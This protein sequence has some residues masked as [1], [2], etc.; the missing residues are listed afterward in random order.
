MDP[1]ETLVTKLNELLDA[2]QK[3]E[4][5]DVKTIVDWFEQ[6]VD[7]NRTLLPAVYAG[8][9]PCPTQDDLVIA[10][11][12]HNQKCVL[13]YLLIETDI[14]EYL[15]DSTQHITQVTE[16]RTEAVRHALR[17]EDFEM[18]EKLY[19]YWSGDLYWNGYEKNKFEDLGKILKDAES[20]KNFFSWVCNIF[21]KILI[22][23]RFKDI[24][25]QLLI[26]F[27]CLVTL[28]DFQQELYS[29]LPEPLSHD[30]PAE[31]TARVLL[32]VLS[33]YD[34]YSN[35]EKVR[36]PNVDH[37][38]EFQLKSYFEDNNSTYFK[39]LAYIK[40]EVYFRKLDFN[41]ALLLLEKLHIIRNHLEARFNKSNAFLNDNTILQKDY[42]TKSSSYNDIE[43]AIYHLIYRTSED[44][45][46]YLPADRQLTVETHHLGIHN[47]IIGKL[48]T[49]YDL[50]KLYNGPV[51]YFEREH[52]KTC[53]GNLREILNDYFIQPDPYHG[54]GKP[55]NKDEKILDKNYLKPM[56]YVSDHYSLNKIVTYIEALEQTAKA[57]VIMIE[58]VL[59]VTGEMV[60]A[61]EKTSHLSEMTKTF[62]PI[63]V[64]KDTIKH[65][66]GIRTFLSHTDKE[67]LS[68]RIDIENKQADMLLNVKDEL[69]KIKERIVLI[70]DLCKSILDKSLLQKGLKLLEKRIEKLPGGARQRR[71]EICRLYKERGNDLVSEDGEYYRN[72]WEPA[73]LSYQL[74]KE[75]THLLQNLDEISSKKKRI[76]NEINK[77]FTKMLSTY[78]Q[79]AK[80]T[81]ELMRRNNRCVESVNKTLNIHNIPNLKYSPTSQDINEARDKLKRKINDIDSIEFPTDFSRHWKS[82][83]RMVNL[84]LNGDIPGDISFDMFASIGKFGTNNTPDPSNID[85]LY[86]ILEKMELVYLMSNQSTNNTNACQK[87]NVLFTEI[88]NLYENTV[89]KTEKLKKFTK[90]HPTNGQEELIMCFVNRIYLLRNTLCYPQQIPL[91]KLVQRY[92][93]D[94]EFRFTLETL[95]ADIENIIKLKKGE[96]TSKKSD[97]ML[98]GIVLRHV[99]CHGNPFL[100]VIGDLINCHELPRELL[101]KA[102]TFAEDQEK[103]GALYDLF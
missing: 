47:G 54:E 22:L 25:Q 66:E 88:K 81:L 36:I 86:S 59:Q 61:T 78:I 40:Y 83:E 97:K 33:I 56:M 31:D 28:N 16:K 79:D 39:A 41:I 38:L 71:H 73:D 15:T 82:K 30:A 8:A 69:V 11:C 96:E 43:C 5:D 13:D 35:I 87:T 65:L 84:L 34:E 85:K 103:L 9:R 52:F 51:L 57:D 24:N 32:T 89:T 14:L 21:K 1:A 3:G 6:D 29:K 27:K 92:K 26:N 62:L 76:D 67:R 93:S 80:Q 20:P 12:S 7:R 101:L 91:S 102:K 45:R 63:A 98:E 64:P 17:L 72:I 53:L 10:A 77:K 99:L 75:I 23:C 49:T 100:E 4:I 18:V 2:V 42:K 50:H 37:Q 95:L 60:K 46:L 58:R 70:F 74:L 19:N 44:W 94:P 68:I 48:K 90:K 55:N